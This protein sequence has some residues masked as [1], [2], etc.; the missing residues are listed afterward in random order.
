MD[1]IF[2]VELTYNMESLKLNKLKC[3]DGSGDVKR[4][5][6]KVELEASLK[7]YEN[8]KK[9]QYLGSKLLGPA[10]DVYM[11]LTDEEKKDFTKIRDE[12]LKEFERG[13]LNRD[14]ALHQL[15]QRPRLQ[16]ESALT[17]AYKIIELVKLSYPTFDETVRTS[18]AKD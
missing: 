9:A 12:L 3:Y 14:D 13:Q 11:R 4:F 5:I 2:T 18:S 6:T 1:Y 17:F 10:L 7:N 16:G 15:E 8:E